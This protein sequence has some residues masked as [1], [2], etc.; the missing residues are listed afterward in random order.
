MERPLRIWPGECCLPVLQLVVRAIRLSSPLRRRHGLVLGAQ[1][2]ALGAVL[3]GAVHQPRQA[4]L[5]V[6]AAQ[7]VDVLLAGVLAHSV[8]RVECLAAARVAAVEHDH[9]LCGRILGLRGCLKQAPGAQ[10]WLRAVQLGTKCCL[11]AA[12]CRDAKCGWRGALRLGACRLLAAVWAEAKE[13]LRLPVAVRVGGC[14]MLSKAGA[15]AALAVRRRQLRSRGWLTR[16]KESKKAR[17]I[18]EP[19]D[20]SFWRCPGGETLRSA[21]HGRWSYRPRGTLRGS[22]RW[23]R[24]A[25]RCRR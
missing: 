16:S 4:G 17:R 2:D 15:V 13:R 19:T 1:H 22:K 23:R 3:L 24:W 6:D 14:G 5:L 25:T 10:R 18:L 8:R 21:R 9:R 7:P 12:V 11:L 20:G